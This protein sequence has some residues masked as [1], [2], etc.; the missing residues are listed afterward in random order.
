[1]IKVSRIILLIMAVTILTSNN[2][3]TFAMGQLWTI[4]IL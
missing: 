1:M 4:N 3:F 2:S